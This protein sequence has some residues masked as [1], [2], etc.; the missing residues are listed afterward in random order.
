MLS[1][2]QLLT[3]E[4]K[5]LKKKNALRP[6]KEDVTQQTYRVWQKQFRAKSP[7]RNTKNPS[8]R[9]HLKEPGH[10]NTISHT[11]SAK[12]RRS[13]QKTQV[14]E[15]AGTKEQE[16]QETEQGRDKEPDGR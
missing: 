12:K 8:E 15:A 3:E 5:K 2:N 11:S 13:T 10:S 14:Q 4:T 6:G 1:F 7:S 16:V 9:A